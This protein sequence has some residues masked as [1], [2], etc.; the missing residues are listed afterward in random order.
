MDADG[1]HPPSFVS[2][3]YAEREND[4]VIASRYV[5]GGKTENAKML[6]LMS[7]LVNLGYALVLNIRIKDISNSFKLYRADLLKGLELSCDNFD[8]VE[9]IIVK[10]LR[11]HPQTK[12]LEIPFTFK[13]RLHGETKRNLL[14][15]VFTYI[16]TLIKLRFLSSPKSSESSQLQASQ[17]RQP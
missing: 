9:E 8:V 12:V 6:I 3:L 2:K 14:Q 7:K 15:F 11:Q 13:K 5:R 10:I 4:I 17:E 16:Y 1:S